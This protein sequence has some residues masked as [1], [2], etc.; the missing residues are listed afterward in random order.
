[1]ALS[2]LP[3][4][5]PPTIGN[6]TEM[7]SPALMRA[8]WRS[9]RGQQRH[10]LAVHRAQHRDGVRGCGRARMPSLRRWVSLP[11]SR[12]SR[13]R[14]S[15]ARSH[16]CPRTACC[17]RS[18]GEHPILQLFDGLMQLHDLAHAAL[19]LG[20]QLARRRL[21]D[22]RR[23]HQP[24]VH[25]VPPG[26]ERLTIDR[27]D[28]AHTREATDVS[29]VIRNRP[30]FTVLSTC[31]PPQSSTDQPPMLTTRTTSPYFSPNSAIAPAS[32]FASSVNLADVDVESREDLLA[33]EAAHLA[34]SSA[35]TAEKCV[36]SHSAT[37]LPRRASRPDAHGRPTPSEAPDRAG[38]SRSARA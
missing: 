9:C 21:E 30:I 7:I 34:C 4:A 8:R 27:L 16:S 35:V 38:A 10:L 20:Q 24:R 26:R 17:P 6:I 1:M 2:G 31:V 3:P 15:G 29:L 32:F 13:S 28:A 36:K 33:D 12:G 5:L 18:L 22:L 37:G 19:G 11:C 25:L 14:P 23:A